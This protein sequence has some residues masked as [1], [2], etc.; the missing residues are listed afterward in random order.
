MAL[1]F[2]S[3][4]TGCASG[5]PDG[6]WQLGLS[7]EYFGDDL[8]TKTVEHN[9]LGATVI[10][11]SGTQDTASGVS[12]VTSQD[13][14]GSLTLVAIES[15]GK[16][17]VMV[18]DGAAYP[19]S[20]T[21]DGWVFAWTLETTTTTTD[22][23]SEGYAY[24]SVVTDSLRTSYNLVFTKAAVAG[25]LDVEFDSKIDMTESDKWIDDVSSSE[26][27]SSY[28]EIIDDTGRSLSARNSNDEVDCDGECVLTVAEAC[29]LS[30]DVTGTLTGFSVDQVADGVL[31][32]GQSAGR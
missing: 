7:T 23:G 22:V 27:A 1:L 5:R 12:E 13:A 16:T 2:F 3:F 18:I 32:A 20:D 30:Q 14:T 17:A 28:L 8:C 15:L 21:G 9:Y 11:D 25:T 6:V 26:P 19:G 4:L 10:S 24:T 29:P 31:G